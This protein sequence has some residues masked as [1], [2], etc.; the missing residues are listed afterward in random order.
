V[1]QKE[2]FKRRKMKAANLNHQNLTS[3]E[4][5]WLLLSLT[6]THFCALANWSHR[7][8]FIQKTISPS[9]HDGMTQTST[10]TF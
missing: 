1:Q 5:S 6:Y 4:I 7:T 8:Y 10:Q 2:G 3:P 9:G